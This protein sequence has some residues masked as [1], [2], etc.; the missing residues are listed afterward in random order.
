LAC[1]IV[2]FISEFVAIRIQQNK[3]KLERQEPFEEVTLEIDDDISNDNTAAENRLDNAEAKQITTIDIA[4]VVNGR[5]NTITTIAEVHG[6]HGDDIDQEA[7]QLQ[8]NDDADARHR[9]S[10][11][12]LFGASHKKAVRTAEQ[13]AAIDLTEICQ[14]ICEDL[15]SE[16]VNASRNNRGDKIT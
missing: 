2:A 8:V 14:E 4:E 6:H 1:A 9:T 16:E 3:Q 10:T 13:L 11:S 12:K 5:S 7:S 15:E